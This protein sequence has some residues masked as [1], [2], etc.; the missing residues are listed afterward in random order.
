MAD[1][2][3]VTTRRPSGAKPLRGV[4]V[5]TLAQNVPGPVAVARLVGEGAAAVKIEPP[6]GD[7]L[8]ALSRLWYRQL[9]RGI[10]IEHVD[11]KSAGGQARLHGLLQQADLLISSQRPSAL[12]RLGITAR[13]LAKRHTHLRWLNIVGD[14]DDVERPGH[15]LTYLADAGL[16][17]RDMPRT[18]VADLLGAERAVSAALL[19]LRQPPPRAAQ[20]GLRDVLTAAATPWRL[21]LTS[22]SGPLGGALPTYRLYA[23]RD[24]AIA[25][26]ALE[27]HF[28]ARLYEAL[29][30]PPGADLTDVM[31]TRTSRQWVRWAIAHDLPLERVK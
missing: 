24:G 22:A 12:R 20:I 23:T 16:I 14:T 29:G 21:G 25:V 19:L 6:H 8:R 1:G 30:L 3:A 11:L 13:T 26:A 27:P 5:V 9:H 28:A 31:R 4:R 2:R 17:A 15:D 18:L 7:P 10:A